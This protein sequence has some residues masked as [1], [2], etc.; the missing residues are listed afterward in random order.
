[1][2]QDVLLREQLVGV[3]HG[4]HAHMTLDEAVK[5]FPAERMNE[6]FSNGEYSS[7]G[8]LEHLRITQLDILEFISDPKYKER[9]WPDDYWPKK[10]NKATKK[11]WDASVKNFNSDLKKLEALA[12]DLKTDLY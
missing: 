5:D 8:L 2:N 3:L 6:L 12:S 1:M 10:G 11:Q 4:G 7:W 9:K